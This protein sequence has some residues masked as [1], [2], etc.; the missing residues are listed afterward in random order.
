MSSA[1]LN[2]ACKGSTE[3]RSQLRSPCGKHPG[4]SSLNY[5]QT[6]KVSQSLLVA[7]NQNYAVKMDKCLRC[8]SASTAREDDAAS[9]TSDSATQ[10]STLS[11]EPGLNARNTDTNTQEGV[12]LFKN[13]KVTSSRDES[14]IL[15]L[16]LQNMFATFMTIM[17][18]ESA[19]LFSTLVS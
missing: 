12:D 16:Q 14:P 19:K 2:L 8:R 1:T 6:L 10:E 15:V 13:T 3:T 11:N 17:L 18:A 5:I 9:V 4:H 7:V